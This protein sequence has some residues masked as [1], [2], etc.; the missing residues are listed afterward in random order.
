MRFYDSPTMGDR[1]S[2]E[3]KAKAVVLTENLKAI[4]DSLGI[5]IF[6]WHWYHPRSTGLARLFSAA[7]GRR[8]TDSNLTEIGER[9]HN[10]EKAINV[11]VGYQ[12]RDDY[13]PWR[14]FE[15]T[16]SGPGK[17]ESLDREKFDKMLSE[18][19]EL[20]GWNHQTGLPRKRR[21]VDIGLRKV[22]MELEKDGRL[23]NDWQRA[24]G[25]CSN[26]LR[27]SI[28]RGSAGK[29]VGC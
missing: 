3:G 18:Y 11:R 10:V 25:C 17:G 1:K 23:G 28:R 8:M 21:L 19:Y 2:Y 22:A 12:R 5:C 4:K 24:R 20:R 15:P 16:K 6:A 27:M 13:S 29:R 14:F 9:I 7:T 26:H